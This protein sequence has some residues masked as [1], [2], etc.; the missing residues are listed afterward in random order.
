MEI[1][2]AVA[3]DHPVTRKGII[4]FIASF[5]GFQVIMEAPNGKKLIE[6]LEQAEDI[7]DICL[8]DVKMPELDGFQTAAALKQ[9]WPEIKIMAMSLFNNEQ[10]TIRMLRHGARGYILKEAAPEELRKALIS[11]HEN[12]YYYSELVSEYLVNKIKQR[13]RLKDELN[14]K[15]IDFLA[16]CCHDLSYKEIAERMNVSTATIEGYRYGLFK[17]LDVKSRTGLVI[18]AMSMGLEIKTDMN[19]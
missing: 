16:Y 11:V 7:P 3:D 8:L 13:K 10:I 2:I 9:K 19:E 5:G 12:G 6:K 15:E 17:K 18:Y 14:T 4:E 1:K